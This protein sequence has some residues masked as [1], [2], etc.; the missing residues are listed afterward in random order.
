MTAVHPSVPATCR[1]T[2]PTSGVGHGVQ[3][4]LPRV[5]AVRAARLAE[6]GEAAR[7]APSRRR[8][9]WGLLLPD[10]IERI[11]ARPPASGPLAIQDGRARLRRDQARADVPLDEEQ[12][13][14]TEVRTV[15]TWRRNPA[16]TLEMLH[17]ELRTLLGNEELY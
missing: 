17:P 14:S 13:T 11:G 5:L 10:G 1:A 4:H 2:S 6:A 9:R 3:A 8:A 15:R 12:G 16:E 7:L